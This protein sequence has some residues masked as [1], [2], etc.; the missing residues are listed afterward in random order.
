MAGGMRG[1][2]KGGGGYWGLREGVEGE[3]VRGGTEDWKRRWR[4]LVVVK[5]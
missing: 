2:V 5:D 1:L 4:S 3:G